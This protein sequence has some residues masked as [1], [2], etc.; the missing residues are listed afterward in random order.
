MVPGSIPTKVN[1]D[2]V[3]GETSVPPHH[4]QDSE[5]GVTMECAVCCEESEGRCSCCQ[6]IFCQDCFNAHLKEIST[7]AGEQIAT[8]TT[9]DEIKTVGGVEIQSSQIIAAE[10]CALIPKEGEPVPD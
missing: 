2:M 8:E 10:I 5:G 7:E 1:T 9:L 6:D 4:P 3:S